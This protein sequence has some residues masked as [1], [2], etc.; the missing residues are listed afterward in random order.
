M[1]TSENPCFSGEKNL[2]SLTPNILNSLSFT[3]SQASSLRRIGEFRGRQ[4]L[5][6]RQTPEV[7]ESLKTVAIIE[8]TESSNR[9]EGIVAPKKRLVE[10]VNKRTQP[11]NRSEQEITGYQG[12]LALIH[13]S[14]EYMPFS[15]NVILQIHA[16]IYRYMSEDG[17]Q[18]KPT[19]NKIVERDAEGNVT[20]VRF[21]TVPAVQTPHAMDNLVSRHNGVV[22][23]ISFEPL[24]AVP[25]SILDFLC[26]H[27]FKDGNGRVA[28]LLT[29]MLLYHHG[30]QVGRYISLERIFEESKESYYDTLEASS[31][32][33]HEGEHDPMPWLNYFWGVLLK[34]YK[35]FEDR[36]GQIRVGRGSKTDRVRAAVGR[37]IGPFSISKIV[38]DCPGVSQDMIRRVLRQMRDEGELTLSGT[39]RGSKWT[40]KLD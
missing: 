27:P 9:L 2:R 28:R 38:S 30:Y 24:V 6:V 12:A 15:V 37:R 13:E 33:W 11:L 29:L 3:A 36:V 35:E 26:I 31:Q 34:A 39:G 10:L 1:F 7:L 32:K 14:S 5:F 21:E 25:L 22:E 4:D 40:R 18:F 8:S 20:R 23:S 19:D 16:S 17:G